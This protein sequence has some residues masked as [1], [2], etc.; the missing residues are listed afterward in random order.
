M[1]IINVYIYI[2]IYTNRCVWK[3]TINPSPPPPPLVQDSRFPQ[4]VINIHLV[5]RFHSHRL[6]AT[7]Y[8]YL[9]AYI[10]PLPPPMILPPFDVAAVAPKTVYYKT[11]SSLTLR[12][13]HSY[14]YLI[15]KY[16]YIYTPSRYYY[17]YYLAFKRHRR[18]RTPIISHYTYNNLIRYNNII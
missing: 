18:G 5:S 9:Y 1:Y 10:P 8:T 3:T 7:I 6:H 2:Y 14:I 12:R 11:S 13:T 15:P 4:G 17:Y 16:I